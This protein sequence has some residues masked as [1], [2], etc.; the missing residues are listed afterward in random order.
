MNCHEFE[1]R[2]Q[3]VLDDRGE[4]A[5]DKELRAHAASCPPCRQL[6]AGQRALLAGLAALPV[7]PLA[8][9]FSR[10]VVG[11][12]DI[13]PAQLADESAS[14]RSGRWPRAWLAVGTVLASAAAVLLALSVVW[15]ARGGSSVA[16]GPDATAAADGDLL[17]ARDTPPLR[18]G[19]GGG[20]LALTQSNLLIEAPRLPQHVRGNYRGAIDNLALTL[21]ETVEQLHDVERLAPGIRPIRITFSML[22]DALCGVAPG[23]FAPPA[24]SS[25]GAGVLPATD[26]RWT[27]RV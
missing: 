15:Y 6:L 23:E 20:G 4:P 1:Q 27:P 7:P 16:G 13:V 3:A 19:G 10:R 22:W 25:S 12:T 11:Q 24:Q 8:G 18:T 5:R 17:T 9:G 21:P 14:R 2:M 26:F